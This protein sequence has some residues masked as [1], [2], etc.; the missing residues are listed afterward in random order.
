MQS[1]LQAFP[2]RALRL[3][4]GRGRVAALFTAL[5]GL[6]FVVGVSALMIM[7]VAPPIWTDWQVRETAVASREA[8]LVTGRCRTR[9]FLLHDC[10]LTLAWA[11]KGQ[12]VQR[13]VHYLFL[14]PGSGNFTTQARVDPQRPQMLTTDLGIDYL[15][16]RIGTAALLWAI[17]LVIG[18]GLF[19][20]ARRGMRDAG[21]VSSL[22]GRNLLPAPVQFVTWGNEPSWTVRDE[23][24]NSFTWPVRRNDKPFLLDP[25]RGLVLA[26]REAP[27]APAFP[28]DEK[29][30]LVELTE[31]EKHRIRAAQAGMVANA[32]AR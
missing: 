23:Y 25:S 22:S 16:N 2:Q 4:P 6:A 26:L 28:L 30:R 21:A 13:E 20:L 24:G 3:K 7:I 31:P 5:G 19:G 15:W 27:G 8:R 12:S 11:S 29:L 32:S 18:F 14:A 10:D 17:G 1:V 9:V